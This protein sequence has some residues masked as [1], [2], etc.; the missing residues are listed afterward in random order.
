MGICQ[1]G[2]DHLVGGLLCGPRALGRLFS[3]LPRRLREAPRGNRRSVIGRARCSRALRP[4][5]GWHVG[6]PSAAD[7]AQRAFEGLHAPA[8]LRRALSTIP[9]PP[10]FTCDARLG[11]PDRARRGRIGAAE[12]TSPVARVRGSPTVEILIAASRRAAAQRATPPV[13]GPGLLSQK[14]QK[15]LMQDFGL[16][17][18]LHPLPY[19]RCGR[20]RRPH[21]SSE[22]WTARCS[23]S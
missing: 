18:P 4:R 13:N 23:S 11:S 1:Q 2:R 8:T 7:C 14:P 15:A 12:A 3:A 16:Q 9:R 6:K 17:W 5:L 20:T 21:A 19:A 10:P 22:R